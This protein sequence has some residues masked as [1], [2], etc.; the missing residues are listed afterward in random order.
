[1]THAALPPFDREEAHEKG[2][3]LFARSCHFIMG[4]VSMD[5]LPEASLPEIAFSGRSNV[6][7]SSLINALTRNN[8]LARASNTPGR[9][10]QINFFNLDQRLMLVDLPGYG[11]AQAPLKEIEQWTKLVEDY[12]R[13]RQVLQRACLLIDSR[14]G[15]KDTDRA[16]FTRLDR[17]AVNYQI[18]LTKSDKV[19]PLHCEEMIE[20]T[21]QEIS[22]R[23][24]AH[25][26]IIATSAEKGMGIPELRASLAAFARPSPILERA[27]P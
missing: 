23:P 27:I 6:G 14:H 16:I 13:G 4:A 9:T 20:K 21:R 11:Y 7:K 26:D 18:I 22:Q 5:K 25:P 19:S 8:N 15:I 3:L 12:L 17:S 2:R 24:A 1:M 10:Q